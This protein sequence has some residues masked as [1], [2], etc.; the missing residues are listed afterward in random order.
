MPLQKKCLARQHFCTAAV[1]LLMGYLAH[2]CEEVP[3]DDQQ[4]LEPFQ[5]GDMLADHSAP[6]W[7]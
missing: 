5:S 7:A 3:E 1:S 4:W 2:C 6:G